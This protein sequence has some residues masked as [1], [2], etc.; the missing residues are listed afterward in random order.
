MQADFVV[1]CGQM[2]NV[3]QRKVFNVLQFAKLPE[4]NN[5]H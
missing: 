1:F 5:N 2:L 4:T 3:H